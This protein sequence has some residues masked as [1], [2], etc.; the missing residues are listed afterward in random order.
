MSSG[1]SGDAELSIC[2]VAFNALPVIDERYPG[3]IGGTEIRSWLLA[4]ELAKRDGFNVSFVIRDNRKLHDTTI[5][6]VKLIQRTERFSDIRVFV[7]QH[8]QK[9]SRLPW[10]TLKRWHWS[11]LW[12]IPLLLLWEPF[13]TRPRDPLQPDPFFNSIEADIFCPF[14]VQ[15]VSASVVATA[16]NRNTPAILFLGSDDDLDP[17][18]TPTSHDRNNYNERADVCRFALDHA[19][20]LVAQTEWQRDAAA[21][22]FGLQTEVLRNPVDVSVWS[23]NRRDED[24]PLTAVVDWPQYVLWIGRAEQVYKRPL[25]CLELAKLCPRVRF[26]MVMNPFDRDVETEVLRTLPR[27]VRVVSVVLPAEMPAVFG[28]AAAFVSTSRAE[29]FPNVFLQAAAAYVPIASLS[30]GAEFLQTSRAGRCANDDRQRLAT[31]VQHWWDDSRSAA[32]VGQ[33]GHAYV[34]AHHGLQTAVD[35]LVQLFRR[36]ANSEEA[37]DPQADILR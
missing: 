20:C 21:E 4:R 14:G 1:H 22:R 19:T 6:N 2:F 25:L 10:L 3:G 27:N 34:Q 16:G 30:A 26:L 9:R 28:R 5:Q 36:V 13:R 29:G 23:Q 24:F 18:Y 7:A 12:K 11:L 35:Q 32:E 31:T 33:A 37:E 8:L 17:R 15:S